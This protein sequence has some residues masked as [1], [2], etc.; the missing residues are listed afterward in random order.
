MAR[1][2]K[3]EAVQEVKEEN[4]SVLLSEIIEAISVEIPAFVNFDNNETFDRICNGLT[5]KPYLPLRDKRHALSM[6]M[7]HVNL[8]EF[9]LEEP[10]E[11]AID[12]E[13]LYLLHLLLEPYTNMEV[14][15]LDLTD[16]DY[17]VLVI[18]GFVN[19]VLE[20]CGNDYYK[21]KELVDESFR[22]QTI[23]KNYKNIEELN[24]DKMGEMIESLKTVFGDL[25][26]EDISNLNSII[27]AND[28]LYGKLKEYITTDNI[29]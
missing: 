25:S 18:S 27:T 21:M 3:K 10:T 11:F 23:I 9:D 6:F 5:F 16:E 12:L 15:V 24:L 14:D 2:K 4:K 26:S 28:P 22:V 17:D 20:F 8:L 13:K 1:P 7:V 19:K 29:E